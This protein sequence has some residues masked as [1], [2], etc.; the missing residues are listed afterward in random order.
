MKDRF[1]IDPFV[2]Q[3]RAEQ[4]ALIGSI[5]LRHTDYRTK[6]EPGPPSFEDQLEQ[7]FWEFDASR[8]GD[9][10]YKG[11]RQSER[12][13]FKGAVRALIEAQQPAGESAS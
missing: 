6:V 3:Q 11:M 5:P 10:P 9:G 8:K 2:M 12:D 7:A 4:A 13:S 1:H